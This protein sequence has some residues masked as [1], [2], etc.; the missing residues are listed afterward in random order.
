M[1]TSR[2]R[3]PYIALTLIGLAIT[4]VTACGSVGGDPTPVA[5]ALTAE[6][7]TEGEARDTILHIR[8]LDGFEWR[9]LKISLGKAG[10]TYTREWPS[11]LPE[12]QQEAA[13]FTDS[14]EFSYTGEV[15]GR[16][17]AVPGSVESLSPPMKRLHNFSSLDSARITIASPEPGEWAAEVHPCQ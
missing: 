7:C 15:G 2:H 5:V 4:L 14:V 3:G 13:P 9:D 12:S 8:N 6:V 1:R 11:L 17:I 10:N 16:V